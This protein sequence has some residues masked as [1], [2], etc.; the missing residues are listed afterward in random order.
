MRC[1]L[2]FRAASPFLAPVLLGMALALPSRGVF[3]DDNAALLEEGKAL[4]QT[5]ATPACAICHTLQDAGATG[6]I[7]PDLDELK[8]DLARIRQALQEGVGVMPS[9][10]ETLSDAQ[11]DAVAAYVV[12]AT[13]A[14]P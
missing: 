1:L 6:S 13:G 12:H 8:P 7:G 4:F 2:N 11:R 14:T 5:G 10:A 3:A 9:F